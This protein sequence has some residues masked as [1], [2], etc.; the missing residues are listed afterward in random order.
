M[1]R[2]VC[3]AAPTSQ[4]ARLPGAPG[5]RLGGGDI[6]QGKAGFGIHGNTHLAYVTNSRYKSPNNWFCPHL[7]GGLV[8]CEGVEGGGCPLDAPR[9]GGPQGQH[10]IVTPAGEAGVR[11]A[12]KG[13]A[14][15]D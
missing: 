12:G 7:D 8:V 10:V 11:Y 2:P 4:G 9:R 1:Y 14:Q 5:Q 13:G 6:E 15:V 3:G